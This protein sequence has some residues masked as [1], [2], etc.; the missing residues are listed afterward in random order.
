[1]A[2]RNP[3]GV[4]TVAGKAGRPQELTTG[5]TAALLSD[6][7]GTRVTVF[8]VRRWIIRGKL[9]AR[10]I[11]NSWYRVKESDAV[12]FAEEYRGQT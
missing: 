1:M 2:A 4:R 6:T 8:Q 7:L 11:E 10:R 5:E 9:P 12:A 3:R